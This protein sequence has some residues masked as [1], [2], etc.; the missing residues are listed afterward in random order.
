MNHEWKRSPVPALGFVGGLLV[1]GLTVAWIA[2]ASRVPAWL[3]ILCV[4]V[5][6]AATGAWYRA[7][8]RLGSAQDIERRLGEIWCREDRRG[9]R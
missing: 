6:N 8:Y 1:A 3:A 9:L 4:M 5:A 2:G 7:I